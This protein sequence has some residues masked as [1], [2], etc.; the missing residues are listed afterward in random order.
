VRAIPGRGDFPTDHSTFKNEN[1]TASR[2][3][4]KVLVGEPRMAN[5]F[6]GMF[7]ELQVDRNEGFTVLFALGKPVLLE[8]TAAGHSKS[9]GVT[10][11]TIRL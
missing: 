1:L 5:E 4:D 8:S 3:G 11:I 7:T 2:A 10:R 9:S 6:P